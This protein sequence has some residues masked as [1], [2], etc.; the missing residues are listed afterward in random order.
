MILDSLTAAASENL[1]HTYFEL[2]KAAAN[3]QIV[4]EPG[5]TACVGEFEHPICNFAAGLDLDRYS[6]QQL[7]RLALDHVS[8]NVYSTP[9]D[10]PHNV[11]E[12]LANAGFQRGYRLVQMIAEPRNTDPPKQILS[13]AGTRF[14]RNATALFMVDQFFTKQNRPFRERVAE[15]TAAALS[16]E[17]LS[18]K[19][20]GRILGA[21]MVCLGGGIAGVYNVCVDASLRGLGVGSA[22]M[23]EIL[24]VS[25]EKGTPVTLQCDAKLENWYEQ[26]GFRRCG[27]IDVFAL[28]KPNGFAI[29]Q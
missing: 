20:D 14:D 2:G 9:M 22:L 18:M 25:A 10:R 17:L 21:A 19:K 26:L 23:R 1:K 7:A 11:S 3:S 8:F 5:F 4:R 15:T 12:L 24:S 28:P 16:L 27:D 13:R 6:A 29:M